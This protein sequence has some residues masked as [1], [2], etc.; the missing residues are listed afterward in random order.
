MTNGSE[1]WLMQQLFKREIY[2]RIWM[3]SG[4][5]SKIVNVLNKFFTNA[6]WLGSEKIAVL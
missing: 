3:I 6:D 2:I 1:E 4:N 5:P